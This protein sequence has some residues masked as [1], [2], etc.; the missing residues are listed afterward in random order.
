MANQRTPGFGGPQRPESSPGGLGFSAPPQGYGP[1]NQGALPGAPRP[2]KGFAPQG[3]YPGAHMPGGASPPRPPTG[4]PFGFAQYAPPG[5]TRSPRLPYGEPPPVMGLGSRPSETAAYEQGRRSPQGRACPQAPLGLN[6]SRM[7][8]SYETIVG[9]PRADRV[10]SGSGRS[11]PIPTWQNANPGPGIAP[12]MRSLPPGGRAEDG[13]ARP[14]DASRGTLQPGYPP[15]ERA[16]PPSGSADGGAMARALRPAGL[17]RPQSTNTYVERSGRPP[18][19]SYPPPPILGPPGLQRPYAPPLGPPAG[20]CNNPAQNHLQLGSGQRGFAEPFSASDVSGPS[21]R[22]AS[23]GRFP[24]F[25]GARAA[26][27]GASRAVSEENLMATF[28]NPKAEK[29]LERVRSKSRPPLRKAKSK[30]LLQLMEEFD[31]VLL[32]KPSAGTATQK[33]K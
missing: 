17:T 18:G 9:A 29:S 8:G 5:G 10:P 7:P 16:R 14:P 26:P 33:K 11:S 30:E 19:P 4:P 6:A 22:T 28:I 21:S 2:A 32:G 27:A 23:A 31:A 25:A 12:P 20:H 3:S 1:A 24:Q 13:G 15:S